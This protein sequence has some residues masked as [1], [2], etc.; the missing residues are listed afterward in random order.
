[1]ISSTV[2]PKISPFIKFIG[3]DQDQLEFVTTTIRKS[4]TVY[5]LHRHKTGTEFL[6]VPICQAKYILTLRRKLALNPPHPLPLMTKPKYLLL[7]VGT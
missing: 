7:S 5:H 1:M 6:I 3:K 2:Q 4:T